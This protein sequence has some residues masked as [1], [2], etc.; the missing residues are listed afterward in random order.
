VKTADYIKSDEFSNMEMGEK[1]DYFSKQSP[2]FKAYP[3]AK[4]REFIMTQTKQPSY[5]P[6]DFISKASGIVLPLTGQYGA[7]ALAGAGGLAGIPETGGMSALAAAMGGVAAAGGAGAALGGTGADYLDYKRGMGPK[8]SIKS[9]LKATPRR[10]AYGA[11]GSALGMANPMLVKAAEEPIAGALEAV[12]TNP[13]YYTRALLGGGTRGVPG[14]QEAVEA[15][16]KYGEEAVAKFEAN[17]QDK[18]INIKKEMG[19]HW[20]TQK[21]GDPLDKEFEP[22]G[23]QP[24][25]EEFKAKYGKEWAPRYYQAMQEWGKHASGEAPAPV[26]TSLKSIYERYSNLLKRRGSIPPEEEVPELVRIK[27]LAQDKVDFDAKNTNA[28]QKIPTEDY[29]RIGKITNEADKRIAELD[30]KQKDL[31]TQLSSA[32]KELDRRKSSSAVKSLGGRGYPGRFQERFGAEA[33]RTPKTVTGASRSASTERTM[34]EL[35]DIESDTGIPFADKMTNN[36]AKNYYSKLLPQGRQPWMRRMAVSL[37]FL[38]AGYA[39]GNKPSAYMMSMMP[40]MAMMSPALTA[41]MLTSGAR[42]GPEMLSQF[43][44]ALQ[45]PERE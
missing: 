24:R 7:E 13:R 21:Y 31:E 16:A 5:K 45:E 29:R 20:E 33:S 25:P 42:F 32:Y 28:E 41:K 18:I 27:R 14:T 37:P 38:G 6:R 39:M 36:M 34:G 11:A 10:M 12:A 2:A 9:E 22:Q 23:P 4:Q 3:L 26:A 30:P 15:G 8:P 1:I 43:A 44:R 35:R 40:L 17:A 19:R